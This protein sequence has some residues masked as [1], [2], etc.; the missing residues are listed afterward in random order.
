MIPEALQ[1]THVMESLNRDRYMS[2]CVRFEA[3][4]LYRLGAASRVCDAGTIC[5]LIPDRRE[6]PYMQP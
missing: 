3:L 5:W 1:L 2:R 6:D 4:R